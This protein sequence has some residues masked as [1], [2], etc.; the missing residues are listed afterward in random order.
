[1]PFPTPNSWGVGEGWCPILFLFAAGADIKEMQNKTFQECYSSGFLAGWDKVSTVRK[2]I[3]A[4]V[5]GYAVSP[6]HL[7]SRPPV[8]PQHPLKPLFLPCPSWV[9]GAS[10]P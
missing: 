4:A 3:I 9:A 1:M 10:W 6:P 7:S 2:P 8:Q 5:N